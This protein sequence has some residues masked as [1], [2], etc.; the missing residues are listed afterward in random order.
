VPI[1]I[2]ALSKEMIELNKQIQEKEMDFLDL[3][4]QLAITDDTREI[5]EATKLIFMQEG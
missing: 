4:D 5:I 2:V 1:D 3:L